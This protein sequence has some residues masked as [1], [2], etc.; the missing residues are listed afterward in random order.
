MTFSK[1][2][3]NKDQLEKDLEKLAYVRMS[4][5][6]AME[7]HMFSAYAGSTVV[8]SPE[9]AIRGRWQMEDGNL[10]SQSYLLNFR[11]DTQAIGFQMGVQRFFQPDALTNAAHSD[12]EETTTGAVE[13]PRPKRIKTSLGNLVAER[14]SLRDFSGTPIGLQELSDLLA[15]SAGVTGMLDPGNPADPDGRIRVRAA[16]SGGGL[17][18]IRLHLLTHNVRGLERRVHTYQ[19]QS[20]TLLPGPPLPDDMATLCWSPDFEA[21]DVSCFVA[22]EYD[23]YKNSRKY[24][25][26][27]LT[28]ALIEVGSISQNL[29]LARTS[30][31][32]AGCDQGGYR[33]QDLEQI[34]GMDGVIRHVVHLT[35]IGKRK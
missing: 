1:Y 4:A 3:T 25:E 7:H 32:L 15:H 2:R 29:H 12:L 9:V 5:A 31:G 28:F 26:S 22:Y 10:L 27:G 16:A 13:L 33:K 35:A 34:I 18:P 30:M 6:F 23:V 24:G 11:P 8:K 21:G 19:A 20:N 17:Y 14:R